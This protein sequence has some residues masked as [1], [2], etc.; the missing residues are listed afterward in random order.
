MFAIETVFLAAA[1]HGA[2]LVLLLTFNRYANRTANALLAGLVALLTI[3]MWNIFARRS[4]WEYAWL[5]A[6]YYLWVTP[7]MWAPMLYVYVGQLTKLR[8]LTVE[9]LLLHNLPA[10]LVG[11]VQIPLHVTLDTA[12]GEA[13]KDF[14]YKGVVAFIYPQIAIYL[15]ASFRLL[16]T[17]RNTIKDS[18]SAVDAI[19][20]NWLQ[21]VVILFSMVMLADMSVFVPQVFFGMELPKLYYAILLAEAVS[22]F[23]IGYLSLRQPEIVAGVSLPNSGDQQQS[24][25]EKYLGSPVDDKLGAELA[26]RLDREMEQQKIFLRNDL[27]LAE[28]AD[29]IGLSTRHLSQVIN[30][31]RHKNFYDY[32]NGYR[33]RHAASHL[34]RHGKT[35]LTRLAYDSGFN[36]RVSFSKAFRK[37]TGQTPTEFLD[38]QHQAPVA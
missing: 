9:R 38:K 29:V 15:F 25:S 1:I 16:R 30:Q 26:D 24:A 34:A 36:N 35:N 28:L 18:F 37:Y 11:L 10:L 5:I 32:V 6:D 2:A 14:I 7:L 8:P 23:A 3:S 21:I 31:H 27:T 33:A 22:V 20:L 13:A 12:F 17:Y 4:D 19:N